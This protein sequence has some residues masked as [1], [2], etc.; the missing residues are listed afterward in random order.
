MDGTEMESL[1]KWVLQFGK[2]VAIE[3]HVE[4]MDSKIN[5][6]VLWEQRK[7][8]CLKYLGLSIRIEFY[9]GKIGDPVE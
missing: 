3:I 7:F 2:F 5:F 4:E 6:L 8:K 9:W 1:L